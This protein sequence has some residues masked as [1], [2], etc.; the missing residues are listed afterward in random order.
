MPLIDVTFDP[1]M[2]DDVL[3]R[4]RSVLPDLAAEAVDCAEEPWTG[5][6][7]VGDIEIRFRPRHALD[8]GELACVIEIR[9]KLFASRVHDRQRR[10][11]LVRDRLR[12]TMGSI[13]F[14]VWLILHE[15]AWAQS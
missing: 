3:D 7:Q 12:S 9:T 5:P 15:G 14:G 4:L 8:V 6:P 10:A 11:D 1:A 2:P 13:D